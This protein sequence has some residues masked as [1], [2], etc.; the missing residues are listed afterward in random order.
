MKT[1][2]FVLLTILSLM[3][4]ALSMSPAPVKA[5]AYGTTFTTS[6]TYQNIDPVAGPATISLDF[7]QENS[8]TPVHITL[9]PLNQYAASSVFVGGLS[10]LSSGFKGSAVLSS[11]KQIVATL[12]QVPPSTSDVR[13]RPLSNGFSS[14]SG[15]VMIP[16][17]LKNQ[18]NTHTQF[19]V[20]N[21]DTG[22]R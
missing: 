15:T 1:K 10:G 22:A 16:T 2:F 9:N 8:S 5:A 19:S 20:Q 4:T 3:V 7:Y 13:N 12:V 11:S 21:V 14:G 17:V 18:F 6:I